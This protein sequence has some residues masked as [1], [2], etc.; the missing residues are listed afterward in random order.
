MIKPE[1]I[2]A[3]G[4]NQNVITDNRQE[5]ITGTDLP[6]EE[7]IQGLPAADFL[8]HPYWTEDFLTPNEYSRPGEPLQ[9]SYVSCV[10]E[11]SAALKQHS[12][13]MES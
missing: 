8:R 10:K 6:Q 1:S 2:E 7:T 11:P 4:G 13:E 5:E 3:A 12:M 9:E